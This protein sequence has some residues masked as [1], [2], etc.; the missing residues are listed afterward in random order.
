MVA[1]TH[2]YCRNPLIGISSFIFEDSFVLCVSAAAEAYFVYGERRC[3]RAKCEN[4]PKMELDG[5]S[6]HKI[7]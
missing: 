6:K 5:Y 7:S 4:I 3:G 2:W 1:P